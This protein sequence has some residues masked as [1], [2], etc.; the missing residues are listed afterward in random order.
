MD[1]DITCQEESGGAAIGA[2]MDSR[3][4]SVISGDPGNYIRNV[5]YLLVPVAVVITT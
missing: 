4:P 3:S 1:S 5:H 2:E